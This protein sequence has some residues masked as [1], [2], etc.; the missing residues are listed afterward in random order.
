MTKLVRELLF[1]KINMKKIV[2]FFI[3]TVLTGRVYAHEPLY[4]LGPETLP[5]HLTA[6]E[7]GVHFLDNMVVY[8]YGAGFGITQNWTVRL[9][10]PTISTGDE[11]GLGNIKF[12]TKYALWRKTEPGVLKRLTLVVGASF[13]TARNNLAPDLTTITLGLANGYESRRWYYFSDIGY[14][15]ISSS[16][17]LVPGNKLNYNLVGGIRPVKSTYLK[18]DLVLLI[19]LN[20]EWSSKSRQNGDPVSNTDGNTLAV[21]PGFLFSYRNIMLKAGIQFGISNTAYVD[22]KQTNGL[23]S[24]EYHF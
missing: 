1:Q 12:R 23:I 11:F 10:V 14:T 7:F 9:D 15:S 20:G 6:L 16:Q 18:P 24:L 3:I 4:G 13:P 17:P 22:K 2:L 19:E 5:K 21:A 8:Q